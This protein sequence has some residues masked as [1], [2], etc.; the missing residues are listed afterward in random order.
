MGR[1]SVGSQDSANRNQDDTYCVRSAACVCLHVC[2]RQV[3][4][5]GNTRPGPLLHSI[6]D[7]TDY[8]HHTFN[9]EGNVCD[10]SM[11]QGGL[12]PPHEVSTTPT[13]STRWDGFH[14]LIA[15]IFV[16]LSFLIA[17]TG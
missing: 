3:A 12:P 11:R 14:H 2:C 7:S 15:L 13:V 6:V 16:T 8:D 4:V 10:L 17:C 9:G 5:H 1:I